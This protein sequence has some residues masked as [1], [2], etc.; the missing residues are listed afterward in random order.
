[1]NIE[2]TSI[3]ESNME[4]CSSVVAEIKKYFEK[5]EI[6]YLSINAKH[7][8]NL[9]CVLELIISLEISDLCKN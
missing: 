6:A 3:I 2:T 4:M 1:M 8:N 9:L 5:D 7:I